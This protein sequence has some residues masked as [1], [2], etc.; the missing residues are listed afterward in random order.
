MVG[1]ET[2]Q[3]D[4]GLNHG[5]NSI[6]HLGLDA[7]TQ[8]GSWDDTLGPQLRVNSDWGPTVLEHLDAPNSPGQN[9]LD[10]WTQVPLGEAKGYRM[11]G[12]IRKPRQL[13][14]Q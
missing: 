10:K 1:S 12:I 3:M 13:F 5:S 9:D 4:R 14:S 6:N 7:F 8:Q 11:L 2:Q